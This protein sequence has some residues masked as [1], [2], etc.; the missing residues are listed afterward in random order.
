MS[1]L[2]SRSLSCRLAAIL[3][4]LVPA[5]ALCCLAALCLGSTTLTPAEVLHALWGGADPM[6][7]ALVRSLRLP[8]LLL[9]L[10]AGASLSAGGLVFQ[11]LL[12]NPLA[13]PYIMGVSGGAAIGTIAALV[14]GLGS[15]ALRLPAAFAGGLATLTI[16]L[17]LG[18][19]LRTS[20]RDTLLLAG[21]MV[22]AFCGAVILFLVSLSPHHLIASVVFWLMGDLGSHAPADALLLACAVLPCLAVVL[23]LAHGMNVLQLG[24]ETASTM[25]LPV[26]AVRNALLWSTTVM[27]SATVAVCGPLGFIGL[28]TPHALRRLIGADHRLLVP[29]CVLG[30]G[31]YL[32]LCDALARALPASGE[33]PV[34]VVTAMLGAPAF[35]ALLAGRRT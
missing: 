26:G 17:A 8:R 12:R 15:L 16:V 18:R 7:Q 35:V 1:L 33:L 4:V 13:E 22:N 10:A 20:G 29:A 11:A 31:A 32:A 23:V 9:A 6:T 24:E 34:G 5:L 21:V 30:G 28:V 14:L 19:S 27:V 25:G 3:A 2:L